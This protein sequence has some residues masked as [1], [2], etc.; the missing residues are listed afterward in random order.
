LRFGIVFLLSL[1]AC[2]ALMPAGPAA[3]WVI[4]A[5]FESGNAGQ[6]AQNSVVGGDAFREA[7]AATTISNEVAHSG[8]KSCKMVWPAPVFTNIRTA[9]YRWEKSKRGTNEF[10]CLTALAAIPSYP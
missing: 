10:Y 9:A 2:L 8:R 3:A 5:G 1:L 7:G 4:T 6:L